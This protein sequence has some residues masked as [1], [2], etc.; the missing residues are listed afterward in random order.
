MR[1]SCR[2]IEA[3]HWFSAFESIVTGIRKA[4]TR[5]VYLRPSTDISEHILSDPR[6]LDMI[7]SMTKTKIIVLNRNAN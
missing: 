3:E 6:Q 7:Y 2:D 5:K 4:N 1:T